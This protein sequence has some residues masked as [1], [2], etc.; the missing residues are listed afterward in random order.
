MQN[1]LT[2]LSIVLYIF[3]LCTSYM[4]LTLNA[5]KYNYAG[6]YKFILFKSQILI[7]IVALGFFSTLLS[8]FFYA[9]PY[10]SIK[11]FDKVIR[12][13][14]VQTFF[15]YFSSVWMALAVALLPFGH[16]V[17]NTENGAVDKD[18]SAQMTIMHQVVYSGPY[19]AFLT[20]FAV[21]M[22]SAFIA[23]GHTYNHTPWKYVEG[24][25][26]NGSIRNIFKIFQYAM[27]IRSTFGFYFRMD[28]DKHEK[29]LNEL[30][31][32]SLGGTDS[33]D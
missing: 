5:S 10:W 15:L 20:L 13:H 30:G 12:N 6:D 23:I 28:K 27:S 1:N 9:L 22:F 14:L 33:Y 19:Y 24:D 29:M 25:S 26:N 2:P 18:L 3:A 21:L 16:T 7:S 4:F 31:Q 11:Y 17:Y 8:C 32:G